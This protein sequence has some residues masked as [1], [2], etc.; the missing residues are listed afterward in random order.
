[1][2]LDQILYMLFLWKPQ[3]LSKRLLIMRLTF[4]DLLRAL[5]VIFMIGAHLH[6]AGSQRI[7]IMQTLAAP[8]FLI[9]A[10][11]GYEYAR[12]KGPYEIVGRS[13]ILFFLPLIIGALAA[14]LLSCV[15]FPVLDDLS[16][17]LFKWNI[18]QVIAVG[19]LFG[20][21]LKDSLSKCF[22][23]LL[24]YIFTFVPSPL[25]TGIFPLFPWVSFFLIG[26]LIYDAHLPLDFLDRYNITIGLGRIA[27]SAYYIHFMILYSLALLH[28]TLSTWP[29]IAVV[30]GILCAI[31][32]VWRGYRYIFSMEWILRMG[33]K[34]IALF[35][36]SS[37]PIS[38][39][40]QRS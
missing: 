25:S 35:S 36:Q 15:G 34:R 24:V 1:M 39:W 14:T 31:E 19:Y 12:S 13:V 22:A 18:F 7:D 2:P 40:L 17:S 28:V 32:Y 20:L 23:C 8:T 6:L 38:Q 27:F 3:I 10:G 37:I 29:L 26:Q 16:F 21:V 11:L 5:A 33:A 4:I 30:I 9:V